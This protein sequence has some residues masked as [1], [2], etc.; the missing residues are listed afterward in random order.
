MWSPLTE[1]YFL[2]WTLTHTWNMALFPLFIHSS[3]QQ[4]ENWIF[5]TS[6]GR[7]YLQEIFPERLTCPFLSVPSFLSFL[8]SSLSF[9]LSW[10]ER[11]FHSFLLSYSGHRKIKS[12]Y[13]IFLTN[14]LGTYL[15]KWKIIYYLKKKKKKR[16]H[17]LRDRI[18]GQYC[19]SEQSNL[20]PGYLKRDQ[21]FNSQILTS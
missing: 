15:V 18:G 14:S 5:H 4:G 1:S 6:F 8:F 12:I 2:C 11:K 3:I 20:V 16:C 9:I 17:S 13:L 21:L 7:L 19:G 10:A